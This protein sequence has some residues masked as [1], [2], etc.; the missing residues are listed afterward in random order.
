[1]YKFLHK[2]QISNSMEVLNTITNVDFG[3]PG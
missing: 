2:L 1:M 3:A